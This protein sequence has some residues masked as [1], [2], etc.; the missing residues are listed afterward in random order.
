MSAELISVEIQENGIFTTDEAQV[1]AS[2]LSSELMS[3]KV[4]NSPETQAVATEIA[5]KAQKFIKE[6]EACRKSVKAPVIELGKRI[7]KL[8]DELSAPV[9][10]EMQRVG[11]MVAKFQ[12]AE[13][14]RVAKEQQE[15]R[16][17][18]IQAM[19]AKFEADKK[20][21]EAA[22]GMQTEAELQAAVAAETEAK[23]KEKE[24]YDTLTAPAP[25]AIKASGSVTKQVLRYE[26]LDQA[27]AFH[28][29]PHLFKVEIKPSAVNA[30]C[31]ADTKIPGMLFWTEAATS[32]RGV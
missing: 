13:A 14:A 4:V 19:S 2:N 24:M 8:A 23:R 10:E 6:V 18:E 17:L 15:R 22:A 9:K 29:A 30:T 5:V 27:L 25:A 11:T 16:M 1:V 26:I 32:F 3:V 7:D 12:T 28:H 21:A 31:N 20:A